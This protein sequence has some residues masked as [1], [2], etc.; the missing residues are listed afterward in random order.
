MPSTAEL[1]EKA[2]ASSPAMAA[3]AVRWTKDSTK[4]ASASAK[5]TRAARA[6][7]AG[8]PGSV[9]DGSLMLRIGRRWSK[10]KRIRVL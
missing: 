2:C 6:N 1:I 7:R 10:R 4:L 3:G 5:I 9:D 8:S